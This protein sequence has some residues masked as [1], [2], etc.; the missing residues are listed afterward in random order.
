M[1]DYATAA[2]S[3]CRQNL[4]MERRRL[5]A[6]V[7]HCPACGEANASIIGKQP[8]FMPGEATIA[9]QSR[10][11]ATWRRDP[12]VTPSATEARQYRAG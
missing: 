6:P 12:P 11:R 3:Y 2:C 9:A 1:I 8:E 4:Y 5:E 10:P 7:W